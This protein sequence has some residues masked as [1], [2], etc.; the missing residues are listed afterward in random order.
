M[1]HQASILQ[2]WPDHGAVETQQVVPPG[3]RTFQLLEK[4]QS[5]TVS[6]YVTAS[7]KAS[8]AVKIDQ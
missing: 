3:A 8:N 6:N 2:D 5:Q 4:V 7:K 1:P